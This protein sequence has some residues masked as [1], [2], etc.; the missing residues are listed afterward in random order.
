[1]TLGGWQWPDQV[2]RRKSWL[3]CS[4]LHR[5]PWRFS[6]A[7]FHYVELHGQELGSALTP[8]SNDLLLSAYI[9]KPTVSRVN[10]PAKCIQPAR[11][12]GQTPVA[13]A[14]WR[15]LFSIS[16]Q[17][18]GAK[19]VATTD[20]VQ[21][22]DR[23]AGILSRSNC[24]SLPAQAIGTTGLSVICT[25]QIPWGSSPTSPDLTASPTRPPAPAVSP[26][27]QHVGVS[28]GSSS[29]VY[30]RRFRSRGRLDIAGY[31]A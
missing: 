12:S 8:P 1:M 13:T 25:I 27:K 9:Q 24:L 29:A 23:K 16:C 17:S 11:H 30:G 7:P 22:H 3:P 10:N 31:A 4:T 15:A 2:C 18:V 6:R 26:R 5:A 14:S 21:A 28:W 19:P 20:L